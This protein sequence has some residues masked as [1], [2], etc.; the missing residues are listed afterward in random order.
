MDAESLKEIGI[1]T[2]GQRLAILKAVYHLK[3]A[4]QIP[5]ESDHYVPP[6]KPCIPLVQLYDLSRHS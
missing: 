3:V 1:E 2:I 4:Q 6:C 5:I